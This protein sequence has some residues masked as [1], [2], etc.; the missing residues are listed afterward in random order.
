MFVRESGAP[1]DNNRSEQAD[2]PLKMTILHRKNGLSDKAL[3]GARTGDL[4]MD[5]IHTCRLNRVNPFAYRPNITRRRYESARSPP[6]EL[7]AD[8]PHPRAFS[9]TFSNSRLC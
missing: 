8:A 5:L 4:F 1:W 3:N 6:A 7:R 2:Q 9:N